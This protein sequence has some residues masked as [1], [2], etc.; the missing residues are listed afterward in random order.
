MSLLTNNGYL[1]GIQ[2]KMKE[3]KWFHANFFMSFF[4]IFVSSCF[5]FVIFKAVFLNSSKVDA[6]EITLYYIV[7]N[8]VS[9]SIS[10][11][12]SVAYYHM[13]DINSGAII[14]YLLRPN[15][16]ILFTYLNTLSSVVIRLAINMIM[17]AGVTC[18]MG[19]R[20]LLSSLCCGFLSVLLGF[21]IL[22]LIQ[23]IIG[24]FSVWFH[25]ITRFRDVI[26]SLLMLLG[27]RLIPSDLLFSNLKRIVYYTPIPYVYDIPVKTLTGSVTLSMLSIQLFWIIILSAGYVYLFRCH[28]AHA[29][30]YGG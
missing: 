25:D 22:Y 24:C 26:Y 28:V 23:A 3:E 10:E 4:S 30:E 16:Y 18:L 20:L 13:K 29:I 27:G 17:I 11:A 6:N 8:I 15:S 5:Y 14:P 21:T 9:L 1:R 2:L 19:Q 7:I 12:Q